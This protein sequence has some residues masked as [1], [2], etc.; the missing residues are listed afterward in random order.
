MQEGLSWRLRVRIIGH[1]KDHKEADNE[2]HL[3]NATDNSSA[4]EV[5]FLA[6]TRATLGTREGFAKVQG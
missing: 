6:S 3:H 1:S 5:I 4:S 2:G